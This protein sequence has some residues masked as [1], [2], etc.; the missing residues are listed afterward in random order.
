MRV[1]ASGFPLCARV[2]SAHA[3]ASSNSR[4]PRGSFSF[5]GLQAPARRAVG[6]VPATRSPI[7]AP[8]TR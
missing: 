3:D 6:G 1:L 5:V 7:G 8:T 2:A 4:F